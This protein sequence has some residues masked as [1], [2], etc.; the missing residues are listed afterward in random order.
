VP[1]AQQLPA[2]L[3]LVTE[4][5]R[6]P[7]FKIIVF[8]VTARQTQQAAETFQK[9]GLPALQIHSRM[10]QSARTKTSEKFRG[11]T[12]MIMFSSDVSARGM[13][14]PDVT[15]VIQVGVPSD[16][17]QYVHRIGRTARAGKSGSGFLLLSDF[18]TY[19]M[20]D[21]KD[22]PLQRATLQIT[23]QQVAAVQ[24]ALAQ[25]DPKTGEQAYQAWLGFYNSQK[26]IR[27]SKPELVQQAN[28][29]AQTIGLSY[30]PALEKKTVGKM[31]LK[32]VPGLRLA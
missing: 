29:Y 26:R 18:E 22:L 5:M 21:V 23:P 10:S 7:D 15:F 32:G 19:F 27:W 11:G 14:Y 25:M 2:I 24:Q 12:N 13:D 8:C 3:T 30:V 31:G 6:E 20:N 28:N 16:K 9:M 4:H 1:L 17:A